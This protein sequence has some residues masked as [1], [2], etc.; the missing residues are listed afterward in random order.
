MSNHRIV[1]CYDYVNRPYD[2]V[3]SLLHRSP[4]AAIGSATNSAAAR[5]NELAGSL[6]IELRGIELGVKVTVHVRSVVDDEGVAGLSP[7]TRVSIGWEAT[8]AP[9]LFPLMAG[10]LSAWPLTSTETQIELEGE[11]IPP[12]GALG[13]AVNAAVGHRIAEASVRRFVEDVVQHIRD[14]L[15]ANR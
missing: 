2:A 11:Y 7:A 3:R 1:R 5:S 13:V 12:L 6:K 8:H 4:G 14:E 9:S 10:Q 15:P